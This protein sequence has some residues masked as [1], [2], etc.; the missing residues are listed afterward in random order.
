MSELK[1]EEAYYDLEDSLITVDM[2]REILNMSPIQFTQK[3]QGH[4]WCPYCRKVQLSFVK[5]NSS[6]FRGY[7]KQIHQPTC[8]YQIPVCNFTQ[9]EQINRHRNIEQIQQQMESL[10]MLTFSKSSSQIHTKNE[11]NI[12]MELSSKNNFSQKSIYSKRLPQKRIDMPLTIE[13]F[14]IFKLFYGVVSISIKPGKVNPNERIITLFQLKGKKPLCFIKAS[15]S[16]W[17]YLKT[18]N[19]LQEFLPSAHIVFLANL[20]RTKSSNFPYCSLLKSYFLRV[21]PD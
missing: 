3:I 16:V 4:L 1:Y 12:S 9:L 11:S 17:S 13:D 7:P 18:S 5:Q 20:R 14:G 6:F 10:L 2:V 15:P 8:L 19:D 21:W